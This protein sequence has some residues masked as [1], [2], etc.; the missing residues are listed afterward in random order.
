MTVPEVTVLLVNKNLR[1]LDQ[2]REIE[3]YQKVEIMCCLSAESVLA[4]NPAPNRTAKPQ[5]D[6]EHCSQC[7]SVFYT[8]KKI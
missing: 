5:Q 2:S 1:R 8:F 3:T 7:F 6:F 4:T